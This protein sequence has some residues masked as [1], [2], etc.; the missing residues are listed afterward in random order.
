MGFNSAFKGL[1]RTMHG[2]MNVK[3][4]S[5]SY[6]LKHCIAHYLFPTTQL[7]QQS[8]VSDHMNAY[9]VGITVN[10]EIIL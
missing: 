9:T 8:K 4:K 10:T 5:V 2:P 7:N 6:S 1:K 3:K